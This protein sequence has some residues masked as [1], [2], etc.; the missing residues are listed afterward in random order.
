M[1]SQPCNGKSFVQTQTKIWTSQWSVILRT[2]YR[3]IFSLLYGS[4]FFWNF[5][6]RLAREVLVREIPTK[7][8]NLGFFSRNSKTPCWLHP[9]KKGLSDGARDCRHGNL[10]GLVGLGVSGGFVE[11]GL[12]GVRFNVVQTTPFKGPY[13]MS[14]L[15]WFFFRGMINPWWNPT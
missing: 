5:R 11:D 14:N 2:F 12:L 7:I 10:V 4:F 3:Q 15:G 9:S 1:T 6:H 13:Q 8:T